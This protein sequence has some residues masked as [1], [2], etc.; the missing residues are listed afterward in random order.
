MN[1]QRAMQLGALVYE[2]PTGLGIPMV[3]ISS[4]TSMFHVTATVKRGNHRGLLYRQIIFLSV[5]NQQPICDFIKFYFR[6][7]KYDVHMFTQA[8]RISMVPLIDASYGIVNDRIYYAHFPR[9]FVIGIKPIKK[10]LKL[11]NCPGCQNRVI[12]SKGP[13]A[14][15]TRA[16]IDRTNKNVGSYLYGEYF[17]CE[18]DISRGINFEIALL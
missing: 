12:I 1:H 8:N 6:D 3:S 18:L 11:S 15:N 7:V 13:H 17:D 14:M 4:V 16:F 9:K 5:F 2:Q 10:E